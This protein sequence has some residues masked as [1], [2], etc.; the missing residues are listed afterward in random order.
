MLESIPIIRRA[1]RHGDRIAIA[2]AD[3]EHSFEDLL[4]AS[5]AVAAELLKS[6]RRRT[7]QAK[8][9]RELREARVAFMF[10]P[11]F[12]Y[13][14]AQW[15]IWRAGGIAVPLCL[16]HPEAEIDFVIRDTSP[17][18]LL[19][20][21]GHRAKLESVARRREVP[22]LVSD[23]A[24]PLG[25][26]EDS[27]LP[28]VDLKRRA[29]ILYTSGTTSR[30]KGVVLTH[31]NITAQIECLIEAWGWSEQDR[32]LHVLPLHHTHGI[33]NVLSCSLWAGAAC[34]MP[35]SF[36]A[37]QAW[38]RLSG[39]RISLFMAVPTIYIRLIEAW[40][41]FSAGRQRTLSAALVE[42]RLMVSGSAAL[43]VNVF[44]KWEEISGHRLLERYGMTEIGM[45]LSNP[46]RGE[47]RPGFVG[48]PLPGVEVRLVDEQ[49]API[50]T[51]GRSGEIQ[52]RGPGVFA[53]Y[54][55]RP[56]ETREAFDG[57][58]FRTGDVAQ[59]EN[60]YYR[61]LGRS[62]VDIIKSG[63]YK[64]SALEIEHV[65]LSHPGIAECA[66]VGVHDDDW[67]ERVCTALVCRPG[68][69]LTLEAL[70]D[71]TKQ[72]LAVYKIPSRL[73]VVE[74]LP[75]NVMGKVTKR[76]VREMFEAML[77]E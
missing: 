6:G 41:K 59:F 48:R 32:S 11:G 34:E 51:E 18:A 57:D 33:I 28:E 55:G 73:I 49:G 47:R 5:R 16:S 65:L 54:W 52:V 45:A 68:Q 70:R 60:G 36:D 40:E 24:K 66:V 46:L 31:R 19:A 74:E 56:T 22:L 9:R 26:P 38:N 44:K 15:G 27:E 62:S 17:A 29:M 39:G 76:M 2:D 20:H 71:W 12:G 67:G 75:R 50:D 4:S 13:A 14:A 64:V 3:G 58:W 42:L 43:P 72:R 35:G 61:I 8:G 30:P 63:G 1:Q 69:T 77:E 10:P 7:E 53:E 23:Q 21:P 25:Q 37:E